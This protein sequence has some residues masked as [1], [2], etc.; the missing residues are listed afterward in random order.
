MTIRRKL[1]VGGASL[2][3][4]LLFPG[5][6]LADYGNE[7][8]SEAYTEVQIKLDTVDIETTDEIVV[9]GRKK[10]RRPS[11][12]RAPGIDPVLKKLRQFDW[13]LFPAY[14]PEPIQNRFELGHFRGTTQQVEIIEVLRIRFVYRGNSKLKG[15]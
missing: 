13:Q 14:V 15:R 4:A 12:G 10:S 6:A 5:H 8:R 9:L 11:L 7:Y 3:A 2:F 1:V